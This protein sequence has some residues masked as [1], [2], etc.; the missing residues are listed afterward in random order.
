MYPEDFVNDVRR[1]F[2]D[3]E[4]IVE[5]AVDGRHVLG[6]FLAKEARS[7]LDPEEVVAAFDRGEEGKVLLAAHR[8]LRRRDL[9]KRW[10]QFMLEAVVMPDPKDVARWEDA[11][12]HKA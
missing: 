4:D 10:L 11:R 12:L 6:N 2:D 5:M 8:T 7:C 1:E 3:R 9:H